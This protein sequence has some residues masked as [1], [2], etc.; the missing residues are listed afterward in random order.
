MS[1]LAEPPTLPSPALYDGHRQAVGVILQVG[2]AAHLSG[3]KHE[4]ITCSLVLPPVVPQLE[5]QDQMEWQYRR[6]IALPGSIVFTEPCED[7]RRKMLDVSKKHCLC[8]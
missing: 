7:L 1:T 4:R 3:Q 8:L 2:S 5:F 6:P